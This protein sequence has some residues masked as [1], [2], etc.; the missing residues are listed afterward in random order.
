MSS[1]RKATTTPAEGEP[2]TRRFLQHYNRLSRS[3]H[4]WQVFA[5]FCELGAIALANQFAFDDERESRYLSIIAKY[6]DLD[7]RLALAEMLGCVGAAM[8]GVIEAGCSDR[9]AAF[10]TCD[11]LGHLFM[12]L[13]LSN[14]WKG[15]FFTPWPVC[16]AMARITYGREELQSHIT[17]DGFVTVL[18][19]ACGAGAMVIALARVM[20]EYGFSANDH[21]HVVA[22]DND[23]TAAHMCFIQLSLL[24]VPAE[25]Y[26]GDSLSCEMRSVFYT[27]AHIRGGWSLR[28]QARRARA[29]EAP[30]EVA[31]HTPPPRSLEALRIA[32]A[33]ECTPSVRCDE[34]PIGTQGAAYQTDL[35]AA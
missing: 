32:P 4:G 3:R 30:D 7:D 1:R 6:E 16:E 17:S 23:P 2:P 24:G 28:L 34:Q 15:Q 12:H 35:F 33:T 13:E 14:H 29:T 9:K 11:F 10:P 18:E 8:K 22:V 27:P 20:L 31:Q 25:V 21:M 19:P 26:V 5:D